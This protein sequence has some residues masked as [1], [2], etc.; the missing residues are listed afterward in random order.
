[1][2]ELSPGSNQGRAG[3]TPGHKRL[4]V[5]LATLA[6]IVAGI[7]AGLGI[8][9]E[10]GGTSSSVRL[11]DAKLPIEEP[12]L[13]A[14][15]RAFLSQPVQLQHRTFTRDRSEPVVTGIGYLDLS[16]GCFFD[17]VYTGALYQVEMRSDGRQLW[18]RNT[19]RETGSR[20]EWESALPL[21]TNLNSPIF[22]LAGN[23]SLLHCNIVS[24]SRTLR[25]DSSGYRPDPDA[26]TD[27]LAVQRQQ[28]LSALLVLAGADA[29]ESAA[30]LAGSQVSGG[31]LPTVIESVSVEN[32]GRGTMRIVVTGDG[33]RV[34]D[35]LLMRQVAVRP[36][37]TP[38]PVEQR[39]DQRLQARTL[40]G[41]SDN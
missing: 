36:F 27:M 31:I 6:V 28:E 33:G 39:T 21:T 22:A 10:R 34:L 38:Q 37:E 40:L 15:L 41:L 11:V 5:L 1:M 16:E 19:K 13:A 23:P 14:Q 7:G 12:Q 25:S 20:S 17:V 2:A 30:L 4:F 26:L 3:R 29:G 18:T 9:G 24:L 35:E 8:G 32:D